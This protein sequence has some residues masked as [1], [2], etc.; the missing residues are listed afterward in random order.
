MPS[1]YMASSFCRGRR[2]IRCVGAYSLK[3][4][5]RMRRP[6]YA[7]RRSV[8]YAFSVLPCVRPATAV[9]QRPRGERWRPTRAGP[10]DDLGLSLATADQVRLSASLLVLLATLVAGSSSQASGMPVV[11]AANLT[12]NMR[13][14][15]SSA[16]QTAALNRQLKKQ[17][18][19]L[20]QIKRNGR[21]LTRFE[22]DRAHRT[23]TRLSNL[24]REHQTISTRPLREI[25]S[26]YR[27]AEQARN[28][29]RSPRQARDAYQHQQRDRINA[30]RYS[31]DSI[32]AQRTALKDEARDLKRL[33]RIAQSADGRMQALQAGNQ[34]AS[35]QIGQMQKLR[36]VLL[37]MQEILTLEQLTGNALET[38]QRA[39]HQR[40]LEQADEINTGDGGS[41]W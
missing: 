23:L 12:Q 11:D 8:S 21:T 38:E 15:M 20:Q 6:Y 34:F 30:Y 5:R 31:L 33:V 1:P 7:F 3:Y 41:A 29:P 4:G 2:I 25:E 36:S 14:A 27:T 22:W 18:E 32:R 40:M 28:N 10:P 26:I 16:R 9:L 24:A 39:A 17:I 35:Q 13:I 37:G 19:S